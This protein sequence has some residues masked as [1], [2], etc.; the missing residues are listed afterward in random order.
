MPQLFT[1]KASAS[2]VRAA[3][4]FEERGEQYSDTWKDC[5][6]LALRATLKQ[7]FTHTIEPEQMRQLA[8][9]VFVDM[10]Y[11]RLAGG[12]K[13]DTVIDGI[14]YMALWAEVMRDIKIKQQ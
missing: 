2:L 12:Y 14:N 4:V 7:I 3:G 6:W 9:A 13:D 1:E 11:A 10:K 5:Q 8:A